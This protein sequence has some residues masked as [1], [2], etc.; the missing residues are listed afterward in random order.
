MTKKI[1]DFNFPKL[2]KWKNGEKLIREI[3]ETAN[4]L[5]ADDDNIPAKYKARYHKIREYLKKHHNLPA[6]NSD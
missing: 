4:T 2:S 3:R 5:L 1:I 6:K